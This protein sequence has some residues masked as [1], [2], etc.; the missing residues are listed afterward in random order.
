MTASKGSKA[1]AELMTAISEA[2][3]KAAKAGLS[4]E[5][6]AGILETLK[7]TVENADEG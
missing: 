5:Q 1:M 6:I 4:N 7:D 3:D 2:I